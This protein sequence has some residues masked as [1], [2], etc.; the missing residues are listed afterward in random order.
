M[1]LT[2]FITANDSIS[3]VAFKTGTT[4]CSCRGGRMNFARCMLNT[5]RNSC[6]RIYT[7]VSTTRLVADLKRWAINVYST[8]LFLYH[9][10]RNW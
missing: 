5:R 7:S 1:K 3:S 8:I 4:H 10:F 6:T 9:W 2:Y